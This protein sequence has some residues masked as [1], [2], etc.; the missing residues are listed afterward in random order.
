M[1]VIVSESA[2]PAFTVTVL[3]Q[4]ILT[5]PVP[6]ATGVIAPV[7]VFTVNALVFVELYVL[8]PTVPP[9]ALTLVV[10]L[11]LPP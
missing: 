2:L 7:E 8:V 5:L 9:D 1:I 4:L 3:A 10:A 6:A 11:P